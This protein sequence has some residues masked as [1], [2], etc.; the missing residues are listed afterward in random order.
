MGPVGCPRHCCDEFCLDGSPAVGCATAFRAIRG[1]DTS[2]MGSPDA[3]D[4]LVGLWRSGVDIA[5]Y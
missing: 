2:A 4:M 5:N 1:V 3:P